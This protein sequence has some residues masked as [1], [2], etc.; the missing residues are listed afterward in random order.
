LL[1][2]VEKIEKEEQTPPVGLV[3]GPIG[4]IKQ[5]YRDWQQILLHS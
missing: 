5:V 3:E 4:P 1:L 2:A